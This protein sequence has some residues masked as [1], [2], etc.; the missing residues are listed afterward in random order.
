MLPGGRNIACLGGQEG[1]NKILLMKF[2]AP[3]DYVPLDYYVFITGY[4]FEMNSINNVCA[5][6]YLLDGEGI[7]HARPGA[8]Y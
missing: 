4:G 6:R 2:E 7:V 8:M 1:V 3:V 5:L